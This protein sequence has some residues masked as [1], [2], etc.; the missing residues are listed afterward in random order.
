MVKYKLQ[1]TFVN[2]IP[3]NEIIAVIETIAVLVVKII[4]EFFPLPVGVKIGFG[5]TIPLPQVSIEADKPSYQSSLRKLHAGDDHTTTIIDLHLITQLADLKNRSVFEQFDNFLNG[6][7]IV[8][9][10]QQELFAFCLGHIVISS[11][12]GNFEEPSNDDNTASKGFII[13]VSVGFGLFAL[14]LS[15]ATVWYTFREK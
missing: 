7:K 11:I 13:G 9:H 15:L 12:S 10:V 6:D 14:F 3:E 8:S 1:V 4:R 5:S 2:T